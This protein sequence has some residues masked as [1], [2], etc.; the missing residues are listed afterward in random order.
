MDI[1]ERIAAAA[2]L[3]L[4]AA[5][6]ELRAVLAAQNGGGRGDL[7]QIKDALALL[8]E[9]T[10]FTRELGG[11]ASSGV[12]VRFDDAAADAAKC[13]GRGRKNLIFTAF[14]LLPTALVSTLATPQSTLR[15]TASRCGSVTARL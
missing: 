15:S 8:K 3:A 9:L 5:E 14:F 6:T 12:T 11:G 1:T 7:R 2:G 4:D 10:S 13:R